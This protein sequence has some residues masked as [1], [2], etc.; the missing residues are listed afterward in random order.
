MDTSE[1]MKFSLWG[2]KVYGTNIEVVPYQRLVQEWYAGDWKEPSILTIKL[3]KGIN[4]VRVEILHEN[5]PDNEYEKTE[6]LWREFIKNLQA[7]FP[8]F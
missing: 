7:L 8:T 1:G 5:L 3:H 6:N 4:T 2:G